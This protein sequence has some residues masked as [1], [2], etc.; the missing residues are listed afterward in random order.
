M[1]EGGFFCGSVYHHCNRGLWNR[2]ERITGRMNIEV[3]HFLYAQ[4]N[5]HGTSRRLYC[6][7]FFFQT[8]GFLLSCSL[9]I[10]VNSI[11]WSGET[12][13]IFPINFETKRWSLTSIIRCPVLFPELPDV[14][15]GL[16][17]YARIFW[18]AGLWSY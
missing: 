17:R 13:I 8:S 7:I 1:R 18:N 3:V 16:N 10:P 9:M 15:D 6:G 4:P 14:R 5:G 12:D 2:C 11:L